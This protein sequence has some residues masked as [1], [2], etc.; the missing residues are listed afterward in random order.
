M[1]KSKIGTCDCCE[2]KVPQVFLKKV[3]SSFFQN[4]MEVCHPCYSRVLSKGQKRDDFFAGKTKSELEKLRRS[5]P[6]FPET[7]PCP[8]KMDK[9]AWS[10]EFTIGCD[11]KA[12]WYG[13]ADVFEFFEACLK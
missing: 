11:R 2:A 13:Y 12:K 9:K 1:S 6:K 3:K 8:T 10:Y 4:A 7:L 5:V